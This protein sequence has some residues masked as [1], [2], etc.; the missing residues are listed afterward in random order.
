M[1]VGEGVGEGKVQGGKGAKRTMVPRIDDGSIEGLL[2]LITRVGQ[3]NRSEERGSGTK[4][5]HWKAGVCHSKPHKDHW[6]FNVYFP[7]LK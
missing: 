3:D 5:D 7:P 6:I 2:S 4:K 1:K